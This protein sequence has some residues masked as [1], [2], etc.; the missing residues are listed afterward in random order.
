[1][2]APGRIFGAAP[3]G[4]GKNETSRPVRNP[5]SCPPLAPWPPGMAKR[6][7]VVRLP[8]GR[9]AAAHSGSGSTDWQ[10]ECIDLCRRML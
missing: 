9:A 4:P 6:R 3:T 2:P 8:D 1:M 5:T 10:T 7:L